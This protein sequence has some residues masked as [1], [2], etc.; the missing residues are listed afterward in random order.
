MPQGVVGTKANCCYECH[1]AL[2]S[3][4]LPPLSVA[5]GFQLGTSPSAMCD[6]TIPE[7]MLITAYRIRMCVVKLKQIAGPN[8]SQY[9]VKGNSITFP[10][11]VVKVASYLQC[12]L[13]M[14]PEMPKVVFIPC[15]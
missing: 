6:L 5:N 15:V 14:L 2:R 12:H 1:I 7:K 10:Q 11:D 4:N 8:T 9:A 13:N 3:N